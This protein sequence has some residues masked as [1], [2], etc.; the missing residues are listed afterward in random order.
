MTFSTRQDGAEIPYLEGEGE[1][2][3]Q[4]PPI[5]L[6]SDFYLANVAVRERRVGKLLAAQIIS[7]F[8]VSDPDLASLSYGVF[9][10]AGT[11]RH[12]EGL[13]VS[14]ADDPSPLRALA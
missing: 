9:N 7:H 4:T 5:R 13:A 11:W 1:L 8:H 2:V 12:T 14:N 10:E 6:T 3:V